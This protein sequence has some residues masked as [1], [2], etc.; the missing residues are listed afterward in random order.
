MSGELIAVLKE[1]LHKNYEEFLIHLQGKSVP[2]L[3]AMAAEITAAKQCH[4]ELL[5]ACD[6][7][8]V[9]FLLQFDNPLNVVRADWESEITSCGHRDEMRHILWRIRD[10]ELYFK[11]QPVQHT[12]RESFAVLKSQKSIQKK[13]R[14]A[15]ER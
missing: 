12:D 13:G 8:D 10:R 5:D 2:E 15:H 1:R 9:A 3:I 4:E 11:E 6:T 7:D 14:D